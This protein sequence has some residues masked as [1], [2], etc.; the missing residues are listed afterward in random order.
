[1]NFV[2]IIQKKAKKSGLNR[3]EI[4]YVIK[5]IVYGKIPDYLITSW[6][7]AFYINNCSLDEAYFL[8][9]A[10]WKYSKK[11]DLT[12]LKTKYPIIDK[13]STG[14]VGD[15][16][17]LIL[18]P[19]IASLGVS[20]AKLSGKG[21][22]FT[23]GTIDKLESIGCQTELTQKQMIKLLKENN[24]FVASQTRDIAPADK[25][26]YTLRDLTGTVDNYGLIASSILA[27]KFAIIGT[28]VFLDVKYGSGAFCQTYQQAKQLVKYLK[29]IA[30]KM[31]R[32]LT[33]IISS[34][35]QP[36]GKAIGNLI[37]IK[38]AIDFLSGN[39]ANYPDLK[40]LIY[41]FAIK[42]LVETKNI[43]FLQAKK[44]IDFVIKSK[45]ALNKFY[46][47][48]K[49][50]KGIDL[51]KNDLPFNPKYR[52]LIKANKSGYLKWKSTAQIGN[53]CKDLGAGR[54]KKADKID[55]QAGIYLMKK[56]GDYVKVNEIIAIFYS[57]TV[58]SIDTKQ[59]FIDNIVLANEK[60]I[61]S[62][63]VAK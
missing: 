31:E 39:V 18:A 11:I 10:M 36:L 43:S 46:L 23:G 62:P 55:F 54:I 48:I 63:I 9:L 29:Y 28:H 57:S 14:G 3:Q 8:T 47:W 19:I 32:K 2:N 41:E 49:K 5:N 38:E 7:M 20:V 42:I 37:E 52:L 34:M 22:G 40:K 58:I 59:R 33:I 44:K 13:H 50:Q 17:T 51:T 56:I 60:Y 12:K 61:V 53:I 45:K 27:K 25:I 35:Q 16:V 21:L 24:L 4:D 15:K 30:K 1:M 26:L 6:L